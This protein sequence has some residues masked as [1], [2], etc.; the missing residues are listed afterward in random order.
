MGLA[1]AL[2]VADNGDLHL[3]DLADLGRVDV[4]MDDFGVRGELG[5]LA[6]HAV[7]EARAACDDQVG[8]G[9]GKVCVLRAV[10]AHGTDVE[11]VGSGERALAHKGGDHGQLQ[12]VRQLDQ[13]IGGAGADHAAADVEHGA[14]GALDALDRRADLLS[15]AAVGGAI[16][17][18]VDL[19]GIVEHHLLRQD[20]GG[21][22]DEHRAG[23]AGC[24]DMERLAEGGRQLIGGLQQEGVLDHGHGDADDVGLLEAVG[25]DDAARYLA[26]D[27]HERHAVHIGGGDAGD[28]VGG[29]GAGGHDDH[30]DV[31]RGARIAV[32]L[33]HRALFVAGKHMVKLLAIVE[34]VVDLDGLAARIAEHQVDALGLEGGHHGLRADHLLALFGVLAAQAAGLACGGR[35]LILL[36]FAHDTYA[37]LSAEETSLAYLASTPWLCL[38]AGATKA[39]RRA[40]S[41]SS[42]TCNVMAPPSMSTVI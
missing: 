20:I 41:S 3:A 40:A 33:V 21:D 23:A 30:A 14:L 39:A 12:R 13:L 5:E 11:R 27:D 36:A 32:G 4:D 18:Q 15:V 16:R 10:H 42:S 22:V 2:K 7:G 38:G 29:A 6:G 28:R 34:R 17:G 8:L 24:G 31:A 25:A 1:P 35:V 26:G 9:H 37:P 19:I